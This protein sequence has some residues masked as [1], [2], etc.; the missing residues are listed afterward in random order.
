M[1]G[2]GF[3]SNACYVYNHTSQFSDKVE[4]SKQQ[5]LIG[6]EFDALRSTLRFD[7]V[8]GKKTYV[9]T[10]EMSDWGSSAIQASIFRII[11]EEMIGYNSFRI[12]YRPD[13]TEYHL[14]ANDKACQAINLEV[15]DDLPSSQGKLLTN[16]LGI[17]DRQG[18]YVPKT[19]P[20]LSSHFV[21][22][23]SNLYPT[24]CDSDSSKN[25]SPYEFFP[26]FGNANLNK[27]FESPE[28][29]EC[30][31]LTPNI[32]GWT[33]STCTNGS[34]IPPL[35]LESKSCKELYIQHPERSLGWYE[36]VIQN[37]GLK[38]RTVYLGLQG[39]LH[40]IELVHKTSEKEMVDGIIY[41]WWEP[42]PMHE[43]FP[44]THFILPEFSK[45]CQSTYSREP[46]ES[47]VDCDR[48]TP[49][50]LKVIPSVLETSEPDLFELWSHFILNNDE[51]MEMMRLEGPWMG[52]GGNLT[53]EAAACEW[54]RTTNVNWSSWISISQSSNIT[55]CDGGNSQTGIDSKL[56]VVG[57]I[58]FCI[59]GILILAI[60]TGVGIWLYKYLQRLRSDNEEELE[61]PGPLDLDLSLDRTI[62]LLSSVIEGKYVPKKSL[63][64]LRDDLVQGVTMRVAPDMN[65]QLLLENEEY[66]TESV[67]FIL[68]MQECNALRQP[69][70]DTS[71]FGISEEPINEKQSSPVFNTAFTGQCDLVDPQFMDPATSWTL[72]LSVPCDSSWDFYGESIKFPSPQDPD[73]DVTRIV[74]QVGMLPGRNLSFNIFDVY[75]KSGGRPLVVVSLVVMDSFNLLSKM[76]L[77]PVRFRKFLEA[78]EDGYQARNPYHNSTHAADVTHRLATLINIA[79][80]NDWALNDMDVLTAL[81]AAILH[82]YLHPGTN[83][84]LQIRASS[85]AAIL[86]NDLHVLEN[87]SAMKG[88]LL[89]KEDDCETNF[90]S[91]LS[92]SERRTIRETVIDMILATDMS[93]HFNM[94]ATFRSKVMTKL[95]T[96]R[97]AKL[98]N[99]KAAPRWSKGARKS[100]EFTRNCEL[101]APRVCSETSSWASKQNNNAFM[102]NLQVVD[103]DSGQ[104]NN[105]TLTEE[106]KRVLLKMVLK[107]ADIGH[108]TLEPEAHLVWVK[109]LQEEFFRQ[110][111]NER[112]WGMP[113]SYLC[114][115]QK[116]RSGPAFGEN[117]LGFLDIICL[118]MYS[119]WVECF[120]SCADLLTNL[121]RNRRIWEIDA[122]KSGKNIFSALDNEKAGQNPQGKYT[123]DSKAS[124]T[125]PAFQSSTANLLF[126]SC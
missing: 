82:D 48:P 30:N 105:V 97:S 22:L 102:E 84:A 100:M 75:T 125:K 36:A 43:R 34:W 2:H 50:I 114:D 67:K 87:Y 38:F 10:I 101:T 108:V 61:I 96:R 17:V 91:T 41:H 64:K 62:T 107:C 106:E 46:T 5:C 23:Q 124:H 55:P 58:I 99:E 73:S 51:Q 79:R 121:T 6:P 86:H 83:N 78:V 71:L 7:Q 24:Q 65:S 54:L 20:F 59:S 89:L 88:L 116:A 44:S 14:R 93:E 1:D 113:I 90:L 32:T 77:N 16:P 63:A 45:E 12:L 80:L 27:I 35:C 4:S 42:H 112:E 120:P 19:T 33:H 74:L 122:M 119:A 76:G 81:I 49:T 109:S 13:K 110:G 98:V 95:R 25:S 56:I 29:F 104:L 26:N 123:S 60:L 31:N 40:Q 66:S 70:L 92:R 15:W 85:S 47:L 103:M 126:A 118:P 115:R 111:D 68:A 18:L 52:G 57:L 39:L 8:V 117:Q 28:R 11:L 3:V 69:T 94:V 21:P 53:V 37:L 9:P 72:K